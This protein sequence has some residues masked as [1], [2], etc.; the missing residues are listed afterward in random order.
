[1]EKRLKADASGVFLC[2]KVIAAKMQRWKKLLDLL[3][4]EGI[5]NLY[6]HL[7]TLIF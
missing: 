1:M 4:K 6:F 7:I 5:I 3:Y 2:K